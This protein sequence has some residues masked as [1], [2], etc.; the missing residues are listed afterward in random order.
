MLLTMDVGTNQLNN[1]LDV[2]LGLSL[3]RKSEAR[4]K[5]KEKLPEMT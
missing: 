1:N 3:M 4:K 2:D 5:R